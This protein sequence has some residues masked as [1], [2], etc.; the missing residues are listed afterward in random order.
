[1]SDTAGFVERETKLGSC[2]PPHFSSS[3]STWLPR[4]KAQDRKLI[5]LLYETQN[6]ETRPSSHADFK[7]LHLVTRA[8]HKE[9]ISIGIIMVSFPP[10]PALCPTVPSTLRC[11]FRRPAAHS[12]FTTILYL[13]AVITI[14]HNKADA[15]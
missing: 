4:E 12:P 6:D 14:N 10:D 15:R 7:P 2:K 13:V 11:P 9:V 3:S 8:Q 5:L 1:M